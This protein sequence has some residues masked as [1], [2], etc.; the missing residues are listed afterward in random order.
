MVQYELEQI[1]AKAKKGRADSRESSLLETAT[2]GTSFSTAARATQVVD[3]HFLDFKQ[4]LDKLVESTLGTRTDL[5]I[6]VKQERLSQFDQSVRFRN[7]IHLFLAMFGIIVFMTE[8]WLAYDETRCNQIMDDFSIARIDRWRVCLGQNFKTYTCKWLMST[9][10]FLL[11]GMIID[12]YRMQLRAEKGA[13]WFV[14]DSIAWRRYWWLMLILELIVILPHPYPTSLPGNYSA[15]WRPYDDK[16]GAFMFLRSYLFLRV[17]RDHSQM[18]Q[19]RLVILNDG[20]VRKIGAVDFNWHFIVKFQFLSRKW[21]FVGLALLYFWFVMSYTAWIYEREQ[22]SQFTL[23]VGVWF[24]AVTMATV[25]YGDVV[26][27]HENTKIVAGMAGLGGIIISALL[28]FSVMSSLER[29]SQDVRVMNLL[30][31]S[32]VLV[33][34]RDHSARYIQLWWS[35]YKTICNNKRAAGKANV[36]IFNVPLPGHRDLSNVRFNQLNNFIKSKLREQRT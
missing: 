22:S 3:E 1:K 6:V 21:T 2:K 18:Y 28:V 14:H 20:I 27:N 32:R 29:S 24:V 8:V 19:K 33:E 25:G 12:Y 10:T 34:A 9:T 7:R 17:L 26:L 15:A 30:E 31:R 13:H 11:A 36:P 4:D 23:E 5:S 16:F 35:R